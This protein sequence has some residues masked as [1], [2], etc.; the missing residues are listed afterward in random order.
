MPLEIRT[1]R[2][3]QPTYDMDPRARAIDEIQRISAD[4]RDKFLGQNWF[5]EVRDFYNLAGMGT[6]TPSFRPRVNIPQLQVLN[7][8]E[9][10][11][12]S[13]S[14]PRI[15]I[16]DRTS[17]K[18]DD[19]R[20]RAFDEQWRRSWV[21]YYLL[22]SILWAQIA[23]V[24]WMQLGYDPTA[25]YGIGEVW[26]HHRDPETVYPD[27]GAMG[28]DDWQFCIWE[29]RFYPDQGRQYWP[30]TA[31][32]IEAE[33]YMPG[34]YHSPEGFGFRLPE[35]PMALTSGPVGGE[36]RHGDA[37]SRYR[38]IV[39]TDN[40]IEVINSQAGGDASRVVEGGFGRPR[41]SIKRMPRYPNKRIVVECNGRV[42]ADGDNPTPKGRIPLVPIFALPPLTDFYPP[43]PSRF[44]KDLQD[45]AGRM[46]TQTFENAVRLNNGVWFIPESTG[47]TAEAFGGLPGEVQVIGSDSRP[48]TLVMPTPMP[49]H[50][51]QL[52]QLL[53]SLQKELQGYSQSREGAPSAGNISP[54]LFEASLYQSK[55]LT[56]CRERLLARSVHRIAEQ[57]FD[58][59]VVNY[60]REQA[61]PT[62][63]ESFETIPWL[64]LESTN[65]LGIYLD[66][67]SL[68]PISRSAMRS[69]AI[70]LRQAGALD[71]ATF[72]RYLEIP[73]S[74]AIA[75][76][77]DRELQLSALAKSRKR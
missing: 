15:F 19:Q 6:R 31:Q 32:D 56:R 48:P 43:P 4:H 46:L 52:P 60:T 73:D 44:T 59:M 45:L 67:T 9:A 75:L 25:N 35:G 76:K 8:S 17:G 12:L 63:N 53:L 68:L 49:Q 2:K 28:D 77:I 66:P 7:I 50:M 70:P 57:M 18:V 58:L 38:T 27:P 51:I 41:G 65:K 5:P 16:Y 10:T 74:D 47:I 39:L 64:P 20:G 72:L 62:Y 34:S 54:E 1:Q 3:T 40:T 69:M 29:D 22:H 42:L 23:S 36:T 24:G 26:A 13:D 30:E 55:T 11:E 21:N 33:P 14:S 37:R 71:V 61:F